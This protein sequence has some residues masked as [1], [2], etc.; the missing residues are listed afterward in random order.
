MDQG[1]ES[2]CMPVSYVLCHLPDS[3]EA[4][5]SGIFIRCEQLFPNSTLT[6]ALAL[7]YPWLKCD[8]GSRLSGRKARRPPGLNFQP[9]E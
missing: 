7:T 9:P 5:L 1:L 8:E 3:G 6:T 4:V 2:Q